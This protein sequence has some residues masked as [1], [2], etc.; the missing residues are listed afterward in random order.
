[1][2]KAFEKIV[3]RL[4]E[5]QA[6][7]AEKKV[8]YRDYPAIYDVSDMWARTHED[9]QHAIKIVNQVAEMYEQEV[10]EWEEVRLPVKIFWRNCRYRED[11][12]YSPYFEYCPYC[13]KKIKVV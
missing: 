4:E 2:Q 12:E 1:M 6:E 7:T 10:C 3:E 13:G 5:L 11:T 9:M 8:Y